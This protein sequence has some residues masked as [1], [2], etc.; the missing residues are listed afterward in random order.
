MI[1]KEELQPHITGAL[2]DSL[3]K[4]KQFHVFEGTSL[5]ICCI[6]L[7]DGFSVTGESG[8][9]NR[10]DKK[11]IGEEIAFLNARHKILEAEAY[12]LKRDL[13]N[14]RGFDE[15]RIAKACHDANKA[16]CE[17]RG[18]LSEPDWESLSPWEIEYIME[19]VLFNKNNPDAGQYASHNSWMKHRL[20]NGWVYGEIKD[21]KQ[22]T[23][24]C[25]V[26]FDKLTKDDKAKSF[27]FKAVVN[28]LA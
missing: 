17:S 23:H 10:G 26:P 22:K 25:I 2:V 16:Y 21:E 20:D 5:I 28:A 18:D 3:I 27:I 14:N 9:L 15:T 1:N 12:R 19:G 13:F 11:E 4:R 8:H 24:P 6:T 7:L